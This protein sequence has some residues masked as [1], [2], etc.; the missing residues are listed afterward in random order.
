MFTVSWVALPSVRQVSTPFSL[1]LPV[2]A[3]DQ[4]RQLEDAFSSSVEHQLLPPTEVVLVQDGAIEP[5]MASCLSRL[6]ATSPVPVRRLRLSRNVGLAA[7]LQCGISA[8]SHDV[9]ARM[10][11]DDVSLPHRFAVQLPLIEEGLDLVG[12]AMTEFGEGAPRG[13]VRRTPPLDP[14]S[15]ARTARWRSPFNHPTVV[16]RRQAVLEAGGYRDLPLMED[17]WLF[18]RMI[19]GGARV[20]NI[21]DP[22]VKY[23]VDAGSYDRRGGQRPL[24]S[25]VAFQLRVRSEGLTTRAEMVRNLAVRGGYRLVPTELRQQLYRSR[26]TTC[27]DAP[28]T[29]DALPTAHTR[30]TGSRR[31][32]GARR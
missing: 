13:D 27:G 15:I 30:N 3:G 23:R 12:S 19:Q 22:L 21:A 7:A 11:A 4:P 26:F 6:E 14:G 28:A 24:R 29:L 17:Y 8:C 18:V 31:R 25:E 32:K 10:D 1:L 9:I 5:E 20:A 2:Y 16:Y